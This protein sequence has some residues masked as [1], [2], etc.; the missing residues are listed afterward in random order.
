MKVIIIVLFLLID[1]IFQSSFML[2]AKLRERQRFPTIPSAPTQVQ[3]SHD[4][5]PS[6][7]G[8]SATVNGPTRTHYCYPCYYPLFMDAD[9]E[10]QGGS[11]NC[12]NTQPGVSGRPE[13]RTQAASLQGL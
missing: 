7:S 10:A 9:T 5:L 13:A 4:Q 2:T 6:Q 12:P 1:F 11:E 3:P 8:V